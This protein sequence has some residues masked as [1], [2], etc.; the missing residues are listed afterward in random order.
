MRREIKNAVLK[1]KI[2]QIIKKMRTYFGYG[3]LVAYV[4]IGFAIFALI[5]N[6]VSVVLWTF[7]PLIL[8][9]F[10]YSKITKSRKTLTSLKNTEI[11]PDFEA[12]QKYSNQLEKSSENYFYKVKV[13]M[14]LLDFERDVS[15]KTEGQIMLICMF[16]Y[17]FGL[18]IFVRNFPANNEVYKGLG[19]FLTTFGIVVVSGLFLL[20][21]RFIKRASEFFVRH[22]ISG[23]VKKNCNHARNML[24][25]MDAYQNPNAHLNEEAAKRVSAELSKFSKRLTE[26]E[27]S[28]KGHKRSI[29][30]SLA[31]ISG[32]IASLI[33]FLYN[34]YPQFQNGSLQT[35]SIYGFI[36]SYAVFG[37]IFVFYIT[38]LSR[39]RNLLTGFKVIENEEKIRGD[40][41]N[42]MSSS[43]GK[44][45]SEVALESLHVAG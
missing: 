10:F 36:I 26:I 34:I 30:I 25:M 18:F 24:A 4:W 14:L 15:T 7:V 27:D 32:Y 11:Q 8:S 6:D 13:I 21:F 9:M 23:F 3:Y 37:S 12:L 33:T 29:T 28:L 41:R 5:E 40:I 44:E 39:M 20:Y 2:K 17:I 38:P 16:S 35:L 45:I 19:I 43:L 42:M 31:S 1:L 22:H